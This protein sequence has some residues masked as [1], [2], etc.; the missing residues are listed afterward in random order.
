MKQVIRF[1]ENIV[2][3]DVEDEV[4]S[5]KHW[6][7]ASLNSFQPSGQIKAHYELLMA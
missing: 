7:L 5:Q 3:P 2:I 4:S 6:L 1:V